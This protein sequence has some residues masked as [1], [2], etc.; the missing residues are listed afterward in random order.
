MKAEE[1]QQ[2]KAEAQGQDRPTRDKFTFTLQ[3]PSSFCH[4]SEFQQLVF[5]KQWSLSK[6]KYKEFLINNPDCSASTFPTQW[7][8]SNA[9]FAFRVIQRGESL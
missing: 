1:C 8:I 9:E 4:T 2:V 5:E 6:R 7:P 3:G